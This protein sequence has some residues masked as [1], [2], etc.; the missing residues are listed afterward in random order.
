MTEI[1]TQTVRYVKKYIGKGSKKHSKIREVYT[2]SESET[3]S[4]EEEI[5]GSSFEDDTSHK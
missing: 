3:S 4:D 1:A 5:E 2:E